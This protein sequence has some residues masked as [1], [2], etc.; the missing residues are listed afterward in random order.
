MSNRIP[1]DFIAELLARTDIVEVISRRVTLKRAGS[2]FS[3]C[4]PFHNE[5]TPSFTVSPAKQFYHCFGCGEHGTA[6]SFLMNHDHMGFIDAV[7]EL[8]SAAG[9]EVP[10]T[11][12]RHDGPGEA[13]FELSSAVMAWYRQ[14]LSRSTEAQ[15]YLAERQVDEQTA[16][17]FLLGYAPEGW[18]PVLKAFGNSA[19]AVRNLTDVGLV[20]SRGEDG[21]Q[22]RYDRFRQRLMFPIRDARGR[23]IGFGGRLLGGSGDGKQPKYLNSP[24]TALFHKGRELYGMYEMRRALRKIQRVIVVEGYMDVIALHQHG[25]AN[26][27]ATLGT[28]TTADHL[29]RLFRVS[30]EVVFCFDGDRAGRAAAWRALRNA[31]PEVRE[32]RQLRFLFLPDG[33][34]PDSL[35]RAEGRER[36]EQ[37][38]DASVA[39]SKFLIGQLSQELAMDTVDGRARLAELA[40][41]LIAQV[42]EG[43]YRELLVGEVADAVGLPAA[44]L[45][46]RIA[47]PAPHGAASNAGPPAT[48]RARRGRR[49]ERDTPVRRALRLVLNYPAIAADA[50]DVEFLATL[51]LPGASLLS[52]V[53][54]VARTCPDITTAGLVERWRDD[55]VGRHLGTLAAQPVLLEDQSA[56]GAVEDMSAAATADLRGWLEEIRR[57]SCQQRKDE[58]EARPVASLSADEKQELQQLQ[59]LVRRPRTGGPPDRAR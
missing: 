54:E 12:G 43:V 23:V 47:S 45:A 36:F 46:Q 29:T 41:P 16:D 24:E 1:Q 10:R 2:E 9:M 50:G 35:V 11:A 14:Q 22:R 48:G 39:L 5:K 21:E 25:V 15:R 57:L 49:G 51:T 52:Q 38:V 27:V 55:P 42:P 7:E 3:A 20:I 26:V 18:D 4:C 40:R 13:L 56:Q 33:D 37:R 31:L 8:A 59:H 28:S 6:I 34:D 44:S 17:T 32:G 53:I 19:D 30:D 58:L